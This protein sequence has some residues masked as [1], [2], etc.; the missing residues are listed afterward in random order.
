MARLLVEGLGRWWFTAI[1]D[2]VGRLSGS[3][4]E[5]DVKNFN[6]SKAG[7]KMVYTK[8]HGWE[9]RSC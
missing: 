8:R 3:G 7:L 1:K 6:W 5:R 2:M 9:T 4:G